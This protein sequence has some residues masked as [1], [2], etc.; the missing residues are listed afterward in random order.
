MSDGTDACAM[1]GAVET[2]SVSP[3]FV[4]RAG[5]LTA[6]TEALSRATAGE[7]Q[8]LLIGGEAGVGK[9]RLI[10]EFLDTACGQGAVVALGGCVELGAD[11][12]P[13][14]PFA[15]ALRSLRRRLPD[16]LTT[17]ADGQE[18]ELARLLPELGDPGSHD[19]SDEDSTAR[20][21][22]LTVRLLERLAADR[23]IVLVLE[24]LH[25]ADASTR[26]LLTY[27]L[28]TLRRGRIVV[29]ASYRADDIHRRHPLRPLLAELDRLRTIRRI[30]LA[31]FTRT[32]VHRQLTGILAAEPDPGLVE[33]VFERSDGNAF[34]VE[35]L[36]VSHEAGC[37]PGQLSDSLRDLLL[38][39][40]ETLSEDAQ[41]VARI[42]AE[43]GSTV[44]YGLLAAV[45]RLGE[46]ELIEALRAA[47][48]ANLLLAVPD[49]D[50]YRFRH[51]LVRE[52]VSDDLLPG[53][54]SRLNRRY[55]EALESDPALVRADERANRLATYWYHAHDPA[56]ALPAVLRASVATR[57]RHAYAEQLRLLERAMELWDEAPAETRGSLRPMDYAE[58]YPP[59]G[60]DPETAA[61]SYLDLLAEAAVA[62]RLSGD[63]ERA[64]KI[65]RTALRLLDSAESDDPLR[66]AWFWTERARLQSNLGRGDGWEEI[67]RAQE[68]VKGLPPSAVHAVVLVGAAGWGMLRNPG[69][70]ALTAAERAVE[71][72]RLVNAE[73][74]ELNARLTLGTLMTAAGDVEAGL[75]EMHAVRERTTA[76]GQF[77]ETARAHINISSALESL[78]RSREA[79]E[80]ADD[81]IRVARSYGLV[82]SIGWVEANRAESLFSLGS[83]DEIG[84]IATRLLRSATSSKPRGSASLRLAQL[85]VARG[86][87]DAAR[88][89]LA[90]ARTAYGSRDTIPQ[91]VLPMAQVEIAVAA[92]EGRVED[93]RT[94]L[95]AAEAAGFPPGTH[96][97]GWP[98]V[99][100]AVTA[101][102][103]S[104]GLPAAAEGRAEALDVV[105]R[106]VR[107]LATP[108]PVW[109]AHS[110]QVSEEIARA[111]GRE[112]A[113]RWAEVVAAYEPLE[114]PHQLAR[115]RHRLADALLVE[116]G[117]REEATA[118]LR[119]AHATAVRLGARP[120]REDV[121]LLAARAR[122]SLAAEKQA[123]APAEPGDD[124]FG[125]TPREQDVLG[126]V[127]A[128][129]TNRQ[130][131]EELFIS[132]K[133][134]SVHVSNILAKL[135]V[136]GR[137]EAAAL[138]HRLHLLDT[139]L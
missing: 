101:E 31:R 132:P 8:A 136:A 138:A 23:T 10:E 94:Q 80:L 16:E 24:D 3:V 64:L 96:R 59:C 30:E 62:A 18:A 15:T 52:A 57:K 75:A 34:F 50:G 70:D 7:P 111:E 45:A 35:E 129:R 112:T 93:V 91:Y 133:T 2:R 65:C 105:R 127:A 131:A 71:Y 49:G 47:V 74:I 86:E 56:K 83:W 48:G 130:I 76:L 84:E 81:G 139:P 58:A 77:T 102:A 43:G 85:A 28:R 99:L 123:P 95:A 113:A 121:E 126:L 92:A 68:L 100:T 107:R 109:E 90:E 40:V 89:H 117:R 124:T 53:E 46:D 39:R 21:F 73:S 120:L 22:E 82:D 106:S 72:A 1:L 17:A 27:L 6:L 108:A 119:Q 61:L 66:A 20:L 63:R 25:W 116:G 97:Y 128:G 78:G 11:G 12:L 55:A 38:V 135:G 60:C 79:V 42:V 103:D 137:G 41:R 4:G 69:P 67:A 54:R 9:T 87:L 110:R 114:R 29:V 122:L 98:L 32:E 88:G 33:E 36:V 14:A 26:H 37:A 5:E 44:E 19:S 125:L 51:S 104:R 118:L 115:A 134:A 13:F